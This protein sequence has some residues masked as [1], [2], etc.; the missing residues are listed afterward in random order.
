VWRFV[1]DAEKWYFVE[2]V[3]ESIFQFVVYEND[4]MKDKAKKIL[5]QAILRERVNEKYIFT[6]GA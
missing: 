3:K 5:G 2:C 6:V 4:D 1:S